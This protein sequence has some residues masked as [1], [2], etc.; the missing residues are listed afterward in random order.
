MQSVLPA[1]L[2][3]STVWQVFSASQQLVSA[4]VSHASVPAGTSQTKPPSPASLTIVAPSVPVPVSAGAPVSSVDAASVLASS[5]TGGV[6]PPELEEQPTPAAAAE[7]P[8]IPRVTN[9]E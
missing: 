7:R 3:A 4:Q 6:L 8:T 1:S 9:Q 2:V 5:P